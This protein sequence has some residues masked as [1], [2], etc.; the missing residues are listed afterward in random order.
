[1]AFIIVSITKTTRE[2]IRFLL[3]DFYSIFFIILFS[4]IEIRKIKKIQ[5]IESYLENLSKKL[6]LLNKS[7]Q[8]RE[9][10][11]IIKNT[12]FILEYILL[13]ENDLLKI[14]FVRSKKNVA[15]KNFI[16]DLNELNEYLF[17][18]QK[19][20]IEYQENAEN[21]LSRHLNDTDNDVFLSNI[22]FIDDYLDV[23]I[24]DLYPHLTN[25]KKNKFIEFAKKIQNEIL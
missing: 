11:I 18:I 8:L 7:F 16:D 21:I 19:E 22:V 12:K 9:E 10:D 17:D 2:V 15:L 24:V 6:S 20:I 3:V 13:V 14:K 5:I 25:K 1:M 23:L 4:I